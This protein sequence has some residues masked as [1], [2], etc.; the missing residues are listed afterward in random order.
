MQSKSSLAIALSKL[1]KFE[2]PKLKSEQYS[3]DSE[4]AAV[5]LWDA[6]LRNN[7]KGKII[8]DLGAGT[9][10]LGIGALMM[11]AK[12]VFFVERDEEVIPTLKE[13]LKGFKNF[14]IINDN[15]AS[16]NE[17][18]DVVIQ[19]PPFGT[20]E[21]HADRAFLAKAF[22]ISPVIYSIHKA[23]TDRFVR[24]ISED[25]GFAVSNVI[26]LE[27][28]IWNTQKYHKKKIH[29]VN[30]SCYLLAKT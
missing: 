28:I 17:K 22:S 21:K 12:K 23:S 2:K 29:R 27:L 30:T 11:G 7:I 15:I 16:F 13:N 19:N 6:S 25:N 14:K 10:I 5:V 26:P 4:S 8:A 24:K 18:V 1:L 20:K 9:G 3:T